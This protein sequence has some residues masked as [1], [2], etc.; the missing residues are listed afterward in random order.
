MI[1]FDWPSV[2]PGH[3]DR[4]FGKS[5]WLQFVSQPQG[6]Q[7]SPRAPILTGSFD[8]EANSNFC[9][10]ARGSEVKCRIVNGCTE[11]RSKRKINLQLKG[12]GV[13]INWS[14]SVCPDRSN[15]NLRVCL[16][17]SFIHSLAQSLRQ[18]V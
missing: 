7:I 8:F 14:Q 15:G 11:P 6:D 5:E 1:P 10:Q 4:C 17:F 9:G 12:R 2:P 3:L 16:G 18:E 13:G